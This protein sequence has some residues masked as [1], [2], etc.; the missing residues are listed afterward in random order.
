MQAA[1]TLHIEHV[2]RNIS[3]HS[4]KRPVPIGREKLVEFYAANADTNNG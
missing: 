1:E 3:K 4:S 2:L